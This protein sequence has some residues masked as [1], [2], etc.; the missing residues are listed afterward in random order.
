MS[1]G[2]ERNECLVF[3]AGHRL[4]VDA[5]LY[6]EH[7]P[8]TAAGLESVHHDGVDHC[9]GSDCGRAVVAN[10]ASGVDPGSCDEVSFHYRVGERSPDGWVDDSGL[11]VEPEVVSGSKPVAVPLPDQRFDVSFERLVETTG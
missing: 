4:A 8:R 7:G 6:F 11:C 1:H 10:V 5:D 3:E 2:V 9:C